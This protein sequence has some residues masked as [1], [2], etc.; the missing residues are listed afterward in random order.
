[1]ML[2]WLLGCLLFTLVLTGLVIVPL[3]RHP[4]LPTPK[5]ILFS[6]IIFLVLVPGGLLLYG[7]VGAPPMALF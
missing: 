4:S 3:L 1:M 2:L 5:K 7:A 6:F